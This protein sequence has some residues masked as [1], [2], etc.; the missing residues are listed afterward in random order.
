MFLKLKILKFE[1]FKIKAFMEPGLQNA[2]LG[3]S[4]LRETECLRNV[5]QAN[6]FISFVLTFFTFVCRKGRSVVQVYIREKEAVRSTCKTAN[7]LI[8]GTSSERH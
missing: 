2:L 5:Q 6:K 1:N 4:L 7:L 3:E 8:I